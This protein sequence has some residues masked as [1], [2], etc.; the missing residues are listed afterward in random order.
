[1]RNIRV[2]I[3][4]CIC[5]LFMLATTVAFLLI[6]GRIRRLPVHTIY[7]AGTATT[8]AV[9]YAEDWEKE[10]RIYK[11]LTSGKVEKIYNSRNLEEEY[12]WKLRMSSG[13]LYALMSHEVQGKTDTGADETFNLFSVVHF[14]TDLIPLDRSASFRLEK[15]EVLTGFNLDSSDIYFTTI[16]SDG[17]EATV[18]S[19]PL[20]SM[21]EIDG[22]SDAEAVPRDGSSLLDLN[23]V[24]YRSSG[25]GHFFVDA[26]YD[27][28]GFISRLDSDPPRGAFQ[29][30]SLISTAVEE[31]RLSFTQQLLIYQQ[32]IGWWIG[33]SLLGII[34]IIICALSLRNRNRVVYNVIITEIMLFVALAASFGFVRYEYLQTGRRE[35][36]RFAGLEL[37]NEMYSLGDINAVDY[38]AGNFYE[39]EVYRSMQ[40]SLA[41]FVKTGGNDTVFYDIMVVRMTDHMSMVSASGRNMEAVGYV[42]GAEVDGLID[43]LSNTR[44]S[45]SVDFKIT[46]KDYAAMGLLPSGFRN[47]Y[48][49]LGVMRD[50]GL[51]S[52]I[53]EDLV[54]LLIFFA[55]IYFFGSAAVL[56]IFYLQARDLAVFESSLVDVA[57]GRTRLRIPAVMGKDMRSMWAA[58]SETAKRIDEINYSRYAIFEAY[59]RFA[60]KNIERILGKDSIIDVHNG[61]LRGLSGT[62]LVISASN[63]GLDNDNRATILNHI[64]SSIQ[65]FQDKQDGILVSSDSTL[66]TL[67]MLFLNEEQPITLL[68]TQLLSQV[69]EYG[70]P[71]SVF[72]YRDNFIYG[73]VGTEMQSLTF[74]T[75]ER[76]GELQRFAQWFRELRLS[77]VVIE[78]VINMEGSTVARRFIGRMRMHEDESVD[79]VY[80]V[81]DA[82][83]ARERQ[84]KLMNRERFEATLELFYNKDFYLARNQ[85]SEI[86][87]EQ[88][89]DEIS[90]WYLFECEHYLNEGIEDWNSGLLRYS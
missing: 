27:N 79:A 86:L 32:Y 66:S 82:C 54:A 1:M 50:N 77:L 80:E 68:A 33:A 89:D 62:M 29:Q 49:L 6:V 23:T 38:E 5:V 52:G 67:Q 85:F 90:K 25:T 36:R 37:Q 42:F 65:D 35:Y 76:A 34:M 70:F 46:G 61:D 45:D 58:L 7:D 73:V 56:V 2:R 16:T 17:M 24:L 48:M 30:N 8:E 20:N 13:E 71:I 18:Y 74:L 51:D 55:V 26:D 19:I 39:S 69:A 81:L 28:G 15:G 75:T 14:S 10:G 59:Y 57:L 84:L 4:I 11:I 12:I 21:Q 60:P 63:D 40:K 43:S 88:P 47:N 64:V 78:E 41:N 87:K 53:W 9:Y 3:L 31:M 44:R 72:L 83:P 22:M